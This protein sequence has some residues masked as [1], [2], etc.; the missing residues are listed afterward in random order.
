MNAATA[1]Q[2]LQR[3]V[4]YWRQPSWS[5]DDV[6][7]HWDHE[8]RYDEINAGTTSYAR[9][10]SDASRLCRLPDGG[11]VLDLC[12]RTGNGSLYFYQ[13]G[14][15]GSAICADVSQRMGEICL[16]RLHA[17]GLH[18]V[19]W[20]R[21][22]DYRLPLPDAE[23]DAV[24]CFET[25]EHFPQPRD[26]IHELGRVT[27]PGG[28]LILTTPNVLW[29]S[30]HALAAVVGAHH[31]EGPHRFVPHRQLRSMIGAAGFRIAREETTVLIPAGPA[32]LIRAGAWIE[33]QTR[34]TLMPWIGLRRIVIA[35]KR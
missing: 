27:R 31:S 19:T 25:V 14:K 17:A 3:E 29:E 23:F 21:L 2:R 11:R 35:E 10:F 16:R 20:I 1:W 13:R 6:A 24:L 34:R 32:P 7:A 9:R 30:A 18:D 12:A 33:R 15:I 5:F 22:R 8:E 4:R 26:L 28:T